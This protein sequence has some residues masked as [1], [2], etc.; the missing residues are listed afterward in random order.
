MG[1]GPVSRTSISNVDEAVF[2]EV[3]LSSASLPSILTAAA[4]SEIGGL[5]TLSQRLERLGRQ[6]PDVF[7]NAWAEVG[8][9]FA[10]VMSQILAVCELDARSGGVW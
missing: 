5:E 2:A 9:C 8:F 1:D 6:R 3:E 7:P 10:V 4:D